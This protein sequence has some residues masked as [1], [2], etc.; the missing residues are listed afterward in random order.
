M[1]LLAG[2]IFFASCTKED[3]D[4][5]TQSAT[6]NT[7]LKAQGNQSPIQT[8]KGWTDEFNTEAGFELNWMLYGSPQPQWIDYALDRRGLVDNSGTLTSES[9]AI[10]K[11]KVGG[12]RGYTVESEVSIDMTDPNGT[13]VCP[14]IGLTRYLNLPNEPLNVETGIT[15]KLVYVGKDVPNVPKDYQDHT[16]IVMT[17]L[18]QDG[19]TKSSGAYTFRADYAGKGWHSLKITVNSKQKVSF[20]LDNQF[21]WSPEEAVNETMLSDKNVILGFTS[22]GNG[23]KAYHD[24]VK[25]TYPKAEINPDAY[26]PDSQN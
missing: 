11:L 17:T 13:V 9:C 14:G 19:T 1:I 26:V 3:Q 12:S 18:M 2:L 4:F 15:M 20:F 22:P 25:V 7:E 10:S 21:I 24:K 5:L 23:G 6:R 8:L 16:Y